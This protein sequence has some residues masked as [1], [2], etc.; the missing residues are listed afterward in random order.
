MDV[1]IRQADV[2]RLDVGR[3][4][5]GEISLGEISIGELRLSD[6][7][8]AIHSGHALLRDVHV[9]MHLD[10]TVDW[11]VGIDLGIAD[12]SDSGTDSLGSVTIPFDLDDWEIPGLRNINLDISQLTA[13]NLRV[14]ADPI[15]NLRLTGLA[16]EGVRVSEATLPSAGFTLGGVGLTSVAVDDVTLPAATVKTASVGH[17]GGAPLTV[18]SLRLRGLNLPAA[19]VNDI[20]SDSLDIPLQRRERM[21]VGGLDLGFLSLKL[22]VRP[23]AGTRVARMD[24]TD[25]RSQVSAGIIDV[26]NVRVPFD[27]HNLT[28]ADLGIHS[29][30]VP[31]IE[32]T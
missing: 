9:T 31:S 2:V 17:V 1:K 22:F 25:V 12:F 11:S 7:R 28:L 14:S 23:S 3:V 29:I 24:M 10:F 20:R 21:R 4:S 30:D 18:P 8:V 5:V 26:S 32:L 15:P 13:P 27:V 16:A 6:A 19:A